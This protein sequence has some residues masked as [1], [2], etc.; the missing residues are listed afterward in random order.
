MVTSNL[1]TLRLENSD[2]PAWTFHGDSRFRILAWAD[3]MYGSP[4]VAIYTEPSSTKHVSTLRGFQFHPRTD[5]EPQC[6]LNGGGL[7]PL[8]FPSDKNSYRPTNYQTHLQV[9]LTT[10]P[11][12]A[13]ASPRYLCAYEGRH[14]QAKPPTQWKAS[15]ARDRDCHVG[16]ASVSHPCPAKSSASSAIC[17]MEYVRQAQGT[18][19]PYPTALQYPRK[20]KEAQG[21]LD[22]TASPN[23]FPQRLVTNTNSSR[24]SFPTLHCHCRRPMHYPVC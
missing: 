17:S 23:R 1:Q 15:P 8:A 4:N 21:G 10:L 5:L 7:W 12:L 6:C 22:Q 19:L 24:A 16:P 9:Q 2:W 18:Y 14:C 11:A 3:L 13:P 20:D